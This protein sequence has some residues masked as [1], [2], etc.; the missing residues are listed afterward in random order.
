VGVDVWMVE[1]YVD[2]GMVADVKVDDGAINVVAL[3]I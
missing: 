2:V 3:A 1:V